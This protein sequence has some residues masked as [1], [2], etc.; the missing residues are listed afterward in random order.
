MYLT[1]SSQRTC[2]SPVWVIQFIRI[3]QDSNSVFWFQIPYFPLHYAIYFWRWNPTNS[4]HVKTGDF[5]PR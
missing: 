2:V 5:I 3:S 1:Q 4:Y